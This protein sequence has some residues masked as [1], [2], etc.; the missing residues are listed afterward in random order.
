MACLLAG[1]TWSGCYEP[2]QGCLDV[3]ASNFDLDADEPC[4]DDC[5]EFP[6]LKVRFNNVW[7]YVDTVMS[8]RTDTSYV[9][10]VGQPF[11]FSKVQFYWSDL[12]LRMS[13]GTTL[14]VQDSLD[15]LVADGTDT[16][17]LII[18]DDIVLATINDSRD[19]Q[20]VGTLIPEG[21][22]E[23]LDV[24][25]G[26]GQ[27]LN[28]AVTTS[29]APT[30]HPLAPKLGPLNFGS[31]LGYVFARIEYFQDT[32]AVDTTARVIN[33]YG[34]DLRRELSLPSPVPFPFVDGFDPILVM[35][36][37]VARLFD[38]IDVR[39]EDSTALKIQ[40]VNNLTQSLQLVDIEVE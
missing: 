18:R 38:G 5:C 37:D 19:Q 23:A 27:D 16:T 12:R 28:A 26:I 2:V 13:G 17:E 21:W 29:V 22:L 24:T 14:L 3:R 33:V 15:L 30:S 7:T 36:M 11:R 6:E 4:P 32:T 20:T 39:L 31:E 35:Q 9:D 8:L 40:F 10:A 25:L 1:M 34:D